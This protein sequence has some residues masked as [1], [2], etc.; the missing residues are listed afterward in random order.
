M[1][2][3]A[4]P[5]PECH[6]EVGETHMVLLDNIQAQGKTNG[7]APEGVSL[8]YQKYVGSGGEPGVAENHVFAQE[9]SMPACWIPTFNASSTP[10]SQVDM[11]TL[12]GLF[13]GN[14]TSKSSIRKGKDVAFV[15]TLYD[16]VGNNI[17]YCLS[18]DGSYGAQRQRLPESNTTETPSIDAVRKQNPSCLWSLVCVD[19]TPPNTP[20]GGESPDDGPEYL[21]MRKPE[22]GLPMEVTLS[23]V[24]TKGLDVDPL[25][26]VV[27]LDWS[28]SGGGIA[29]SG[30]KLL[31]KSDV[32][33]IRSV[34]KLPETLANVRNALCPR[35]DGPADTFVV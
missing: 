20:G 21:L 13:N 4:Q 19:Q 6:T 1:Q 16:S 25:R 24:S 5:H 33:E 18:G 35:T 12:P 29:F 32:I 10:E 22:Q 2:A 17:W 31:N 26:S 27:L 23:A 11:K 7:V 15:H 9:N 3:L 34:L 8:N 14:S 30:E 28:T